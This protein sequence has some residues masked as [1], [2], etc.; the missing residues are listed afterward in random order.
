MHVRRRARTVALACG[1]LLVGSGCS[2]FQSEGPEKTATSLASALRSG[3]LG[4]VEFTGDPATVRRQWKS[5]TESL[6][7]V[8]HRVELVN[9][10]QDGDTATAKLAWTWNVGTKKK[11]TYQTKA[12]LTDSDGWAVKFAPS[13]VEPSLR[14]GETLDR[15]TETAERGDILGADG[16]KIVTQRPVTRFG[17]DKSKVGAEQATAGARQLAEL[18]DIDADDLASRVAGAGE[19]AF[20]EAIVLRQD[21]AGEYAGQYESIPGVLAIEDELPLAPTRNFAQPLLGTVGPVTAELIKKSEGKYQIGDEVGLSGLQRRYD[22]SLTGERGQVVKAVSPD[23]EKSRELFAAP[24]GA[25]SPL[26]TTF[27]VDLQKAAEE[28]L[29]GESSTSALVAIRPSDGHILAAANAPESTG[30]AAAT[31]GRYPPGST[32]KVVTSLALL[33]A[34]VSPDDPAPCTNTLNVNGKNFKNYDDYPSGELGDISL[35]TAFANSCNTS[36]IQARDK[37]DQKALSEAAAALGLG[38]DQDLG[39]PAYLGSVPAE[40]EG[41]VH[42]ASMIGQG[43]LLASP[44]AM[45][46]VAAS[47]A[48][49]KTVVPRLLPEHGAKTFEKPDKPLTEGEAEQLRSLMRGVVTE[50]SAGF[51]SDVPDEPVLAKTGTAEY[52]QS[53]PP[54]THGWMIGVHGDLAVA[55]FIE[56]GES[57]SGSA[58][59]PL[60]E[61]LKAAG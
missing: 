6:G 29:A 3:K 35:R 12:T 25:G 34:G 1:L 54:D 26:E 56:E 42:A 43:K 27:D 16:A 22:D 45:A 10:E 21:E 49:G 58:G 2:L 24:A 31:V 7:D 28:A 17:I 11:W 38:V 8:A 41:T 37:V 44:M 20:V 40:G 4:Q 13:M 19:K 59:P 60:E 5:I 53:V 30:L 46:T 23:G 47:V 18:L 51:L 33:R 9:V 55:V 61:F 57:G 32:F 36:F 14:K 48:S 39:F 50:G 15:S 52:G